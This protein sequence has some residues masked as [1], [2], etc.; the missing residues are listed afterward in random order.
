M[1]NKVNYS[2]FDININLFTPIILHRVGNLPGGIYFIIIVL[3]CQIILSIFILSIRFQT[4][5]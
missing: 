2:Q 3:F 1:M 5:P 4:E